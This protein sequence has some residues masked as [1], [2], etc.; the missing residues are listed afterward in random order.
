MVEE[1]YVNRFQRWKEARLRHRGLHLFL[2]RGGVNLYKRLAL[3]PC[4]QLSRHPEV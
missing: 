3:T 2:R 4:T 1:R